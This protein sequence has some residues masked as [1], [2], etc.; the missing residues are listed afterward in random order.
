MQ[1]NVNFLSKK[2]ISVI[3]Q[4]TMDCNLRCKHCYEKDQCYASEIM[5]Y[6]TL[7]CIIEK[8]QKEYE[9]V[10]YEWF[11]GEPLLAGVDFYQK[12]VEFQNKHA[13]PGQRI[14]NFI[15]TNGVLLNEENIL[16]FKNN[17]F[18]LSISY[19]GIS[20]NELRQETDTVEKNLS[21]ARQLDYEIPIISI[22]HNRNCN[23]LV[24]LYEDFKQKKLKFQL[25]TIFNVKDNLSVSQYLMTDVEY[26]KA[27]KTFFDYW[28][29]DT[30]G[31]LVSPLSKYLEMILGF[32]S[33]GRICEL[34]GCMFKWISFDPQGNIY[35]CTRLFDDAFN[36]CNIIEIQSVVDVYSNEKYLEICKSAI[37]RRKSCLESNCHV[38][39]YCNGGANC[40]CYHELGDISKYD[41]QLCRFN[42]TFFPYVKERIFE[43]ADNLDA[44]EDKLN[45]YVLRMLYEYKSKTR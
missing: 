45:P 42:K 32:G 39:E 17:G 10:D 13:M 7:E 22:V 18:I 8:L 5:S 27:M 44:Y 11:G 25:N 1:T 9:R 35:P 15:Q 24:E 40:H 2:Y 6:K 3:I 23:K 43:I 12:V 20:N 19:D 14:K 29:Y 33:R 28:L 16:F 36:I 41:T 21:L 31:I 4:V 38:Y 37:E 26:V 34:V 30:N